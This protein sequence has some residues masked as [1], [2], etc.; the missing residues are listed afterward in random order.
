LEVTEILPIFAV[1]TT[2]IFI[3][4]IKPMSFIFALILLYAVVKSVNS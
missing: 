3:S 1:A 2:K 4:K